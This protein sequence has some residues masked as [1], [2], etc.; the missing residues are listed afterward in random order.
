MAGP[1]IA[2]VGTIAKAIGAAGALASGISALTRK[3]ETPKA[4]AVGTAP[5]ELPPPADR[6]D[7]EVQQRTRERR[8]IMAS[9]RSLSSTVM[10]N[11]TQES[12]TLRRSSL[13]GG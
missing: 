9:R 11:S 10:N 2:V 13:L 4:P 1:E 7:S 3:P 8:R 6:G 12:G 5:N